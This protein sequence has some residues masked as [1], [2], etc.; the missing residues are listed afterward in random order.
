MKTI[1]AL[2]ACVLALTFAV[3]AQTQTQAQP[4][5]LYKRLGGYDAT[6]AVTD[7]FLGRLSV[8]PQFARFF[9]GHSTDSIKRLRQHVVDFL[10]SATGGP[11]VYMGR[12]MK[13]SHAGLGITGAEWDASVKSLVA[14]LDKLNVPA[15]EKDEVLGAVSS[16]KKDI[17]DKP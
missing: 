1:T 2:A 11:C 13:T 12:D 15:K 9:S 6:V 14:T 17:V 16:L 8:D 4:P 3:P 7:D 5:T 10:C